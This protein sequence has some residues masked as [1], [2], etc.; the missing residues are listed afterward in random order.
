MLGFGFETPLLR[1]GAVVRV[2]GKLFHCFIGKT[3]YDRVF[4]TLGDCSKKSMETLKSRK[5][6]ISKF[7]C[8]DLNSGNNSHMLSGAGKLAF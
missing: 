4:S 2:A 5:A 7:L 6:V 8:I 3:L 1:L